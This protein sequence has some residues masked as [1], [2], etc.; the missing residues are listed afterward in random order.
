MDFSGYLDLSDSV[1]CI[2]SVEKKPDGG[3]GDI[4]IVTGNQ[5]YIDSIERNEDANSDLAKEK[6]FVPNSLYTKYFPFDLNF[7]DF[8]YRAA[9]KKEVLHTYVHPERFPIWFNLFFMPVKSDDENIGYCSY[10]YTITVNADSELMSNISLETASDV[11]ETCIKLY[12]SSDF[13][14]SIDDAIMHI[15]D[16]CNANRCVLLMTDFNARTCEVISDSHIIEGSK[17]PIQSIITNDFFDIVSTWPATIAGSDFFMLKNANDM[18]VLKERNP[19]WYESLIKY[20]VNTLVLFPLNYNGET[21]GYIWVTDFSEEDALKIRE[22]LELTTYFIS[23]AVANHQMVQQLEVMST[24]D[25]LTG[26]KNRNAM[27]K[28]VQELVD[29]KKAYPDSLYVVFADLNGLKKVNDNEGHVAGDL[30]LKNAA[31]ALQNTFPGQE[32]YRAGG[33]EFTVFVSGMNDSEFEEKYGMLRQY[34]DVTKNNG[35]CFAIGC[36]KDDGKNDIRADMAAADER[37]YADKEEYYKRHPDLR[38]K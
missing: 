22:T 21:K 37:M 27:N 29:G 24:I 16:L 1:T 20:E 32:I 11:L 30:L 2:M 34:S 17:G 25:L 15:R 23:Y 13:Q 9:V 14:T 31:I 28:R 5:A 6:I 18:Q 38:H 8:C 10:T 19:V 7:E 3:Y 26:V 12:S 35:V 33:D 4:R 36:C